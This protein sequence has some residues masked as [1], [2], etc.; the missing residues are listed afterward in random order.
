M[1]LGHPMTHHSAGWDEDF[2]SD[3]NADGEFPNWYGSFSMTQGCQ[4]STR[5]SG[6]TCFMAENHRKFLLRFKIL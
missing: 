1:V 6:T 2:L 5:Y 3:G 4:K